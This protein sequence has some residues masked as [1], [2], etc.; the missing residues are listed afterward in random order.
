MMFEDNEDTPVTLTINKA[1]AN[2]YQTWREKEEKQKLTAR[3]GSDIEDDSDEESEDE[4]AQ[5]WTDELEKE[6]L[7]CYSILKKHDPKIYDS[8]TTFFNAS[9][10]NDNNQI[11]KKKKEKKMTLKDAEIQ[12]AF[13]EAMNKDEDHND[14]HIQTNGKKSIIEEQEEIKKSIK[15]VLSTTDDDVLLT[16]KI[17]TEA[18]KVKEEEAYIEWLKGQKTELPDSSIKSDLKYLHDYWND[19]SLSERDRFLRDFILNKMHLQHADDDDDDDDETRIP[20]YD[21]IINQKEDDDE[22]FEKAEE[23]ERKFNFRYQ[24][25][26]SEFLKRYPR[27]IDDSVRRKD[28]RRKLQRAEKKQRK[29]FERKQKLEEIKRLKNLKK[30]EIFDKMKRLKTV[31]GDEDLPVNIDDLDADFD[32]K[33]YDRRMQELFNDDYYQKGTDETDKPEISDEELQVEN[34][35]NTEEEQVSKP[36][37]SN[38]QEEQTTKKSKKKSKLRQAIAQTK[39]TFNPKEKSFEQYFN[40]YYKLDCEDFIGDMPVRFQYRQV[41]PNNFG[42]TVEEILAAE[43]RELNAWC[44]LKKTSQYRSKDEELR[45]YHV[46]KNKAKNIEKKQQILTSVYQEKN[47]NDER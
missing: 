29:E 3:Y 8:N 27:T 23:F 15:N 41:E 37:Q 21:E 1:Y 25:P 44:S 28:D 19:P 39:P 36:V 32:P 6:F 40:E 10:S 17:K 26:D 18:E 47:N 13:A 2:K 34:W 20:S 38:T 7:R 14:N 43:D 31:A 33:E 9:T 22:E 35:D 4:N 42:L 24:E 5:E 46:Y 12:Y 11:N 45:D 30:K 16:K